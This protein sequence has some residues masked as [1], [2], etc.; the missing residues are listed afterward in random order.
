MTALERRLEAATRLVEQAAMRALRMRPAPGAATGATL[1]GAQDWLTE[2][3]GA[4][5]AMIFQALAE[6][7][8]DDGLIGEE[9]GRHGAADL[10][11]VL[12][13]IDGTANFARGGN[14]WCVSLGLLEGTAPLLGVIVAPALGETFAACRDRGAT[15]NGAPIAA[16]ATPSLD[17]AIVECGW[18][19]RRPAERFTHLVQDVVRAG[20]AIRLGGSGALG[21]A[22][23]AAGRL[24]A[25]VELHINLWDVAGALALLA[26][27]GAFVS[28]FLEHEAGQ[29]GPILA[30]APAVSA[31]LAR[32]VDFASW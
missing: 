15:L 9:T 29:G 21:L 27:A 10:R 16:A 13:P 22:E 30:A 20:A 5:E 6:Q 18:S 23:V 31:P 32:A 1:K 4:I 26:E 12:D 14:R 3:D 24:D 7:F 25:Y 11:W 28:P 8:P 19:T 17:R 2:A